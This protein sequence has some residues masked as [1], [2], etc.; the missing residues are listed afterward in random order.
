MWLQTAGSLYFW[1]ASLAGPQYGP[2][3]AFITVREGGREGGRERRNE[4]IGGLASTV[5]L[6][7]EGVLGRV[8]FHSHPFVTVKRGEIGTGYSTEDEMEQVTPQDGAI[9]AVTLQVLTV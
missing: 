2:I 4:H 7:H 3:A 8:V 6:G 9:A 1:A 5:Q